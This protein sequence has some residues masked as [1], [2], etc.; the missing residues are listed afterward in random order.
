MQPKRGTPT[1]GA[2]ALAKATTA[3]ETCPTATGSDGERLSVRVD[4]GK[5]K[6]AGALALWKAYIKLAPSEGQGSGARLTLDGWEC[7]ASSAARAKVEFGGCS[8]GDSAFTI[9]PGG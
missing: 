7:I 9:I 4:S 6:C 5:V 8:A 2:P 3:G 1:T